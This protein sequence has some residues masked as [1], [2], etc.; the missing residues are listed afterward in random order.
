MSITAIL[1]DFDGTLADTAPDLAGAANLQRTK[2]NLPAL[3][4]E[5]LRPVASQGAR[6]LLR[7]ALGLATDDPAYPEARD[8]F[9]QDYAATKD[10]Q[11]RLFPGVLELLAQIESAGM[12]WG[13]VTNKVAW[14]AEPLIASLELNAGVVVCGDTTPHAK[15]HPEPLL[16]AAR[17]LDKAPD[18]C[19]YVGDD[20]RDVLAGKAAGMPTVAAAWGYCGEDQPVTEWAADRIADDPQGVWAAIQSLVAER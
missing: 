14:L 5:Q 4:Y 11:S 6:G 12:Q 13:I 9:L 16:H 15:P 7:V 17:M 8:A 3:A 18:A 1:F 19:I 20:L 10:Q 2:R